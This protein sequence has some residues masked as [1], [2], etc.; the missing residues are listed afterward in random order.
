MDEWGSAPHLVG[1]S[2]LGW[3]RHCL[4]HR[5]LSPFNVSSALALCWLR[6]GCLPN[7]TRPTA[8]NDEARYMG[9]STHFALCAFP[10][11]RLRSRRYATP[12][13]YKCVEY[14][15]VDD[16]PIHVAPKRVERKCVPLKCI[17]RNALQG[18]SWLVIGENSQTMRTNIR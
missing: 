3:G 9:S 8:C 15:Y 4:V 14:V 11:V 17:R 7:T 2:S 5:P 12:A 18:N 6:M 1:W 16:A 13:L 10:W